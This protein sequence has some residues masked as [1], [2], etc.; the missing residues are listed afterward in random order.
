MTLPRTNIVFEDAWRI[1]SRVRAGLLEAK[2]T[3]VVVARLDE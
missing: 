1:T 3:S 2:P